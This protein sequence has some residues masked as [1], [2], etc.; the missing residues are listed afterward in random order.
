[1][2]SPDSPPLLLSD[3]DVP[4][5]PSNASSEYESLSPA[6][7]LKK[8]EEAWCNELLA[9]ELL[10]HKTEIVEVVMEQLLHIQEENLSRVRGDSFVA[11]I[12]KLE[13]ERIKYVLCSYLR[14]RLKKIEV[15]VI[16]VLE[17]EANKESSAGSKL[18]PEE[19]VYAKEFAD[20]MKVH[21]ETLVLR[22][23]PSSFQTLDHKK[24]ATAP[25][26]DSF[27]FARAVENVDDIA[28]NEDTQVSMSPGMQVIAPYHPLSTL[29]QSGALQLI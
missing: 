8:L 28:I 25:S 10:D 14:T 5:T 24:A 20:N 19:L 1:M 21:M 27:V 2:A 16:F 6:D 15:N 9:P 17:E 4:A 3:N 12:H 29:V 26:L 18:S 11:G 7:V 23:M 22:H 13:L